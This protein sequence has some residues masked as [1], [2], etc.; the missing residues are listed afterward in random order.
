[1]RDRIGQSVSVF[2]ILVA[3]IWA[4]PASAENLIY[5]GDF[6]LGDVGF[7]TD[8]P[9]AP[10]TFGYQI[11]RN[12]NEDWYS[13][14]ASFGDHTT[15]DGFMLAVDGATILNQVV[16]EQTVTL[17]IQQLY[18]FSVWVAPMSSPNPADL[19][20][21]IEQGGI[22]RRLGGLKLSSEPGVWT[23]FSRRFIVGPQ[24]QTGPATIKIVNME[25]AGV[26]NDF[27]LDDLR[28]SVIPEPST[29]VLVGLAM[30]FGIGLWMR[31]R[32]KSA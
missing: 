2:A 20:F 23:K 29:L 9:N 18:D 17:P 7:N 24:I 12:P 4:S 15:G 25:T 1:M 32:R 8:Y 3:L 30:P 14:F 28:L 26:G 27:A 10:Q 16:W 13:G 31:Q 21:Q 6:E 11:V 22:N 19:E 5:N